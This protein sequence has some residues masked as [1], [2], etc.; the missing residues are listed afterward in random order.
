MI[1]ANNEVAV[2]GTPAALVD[3]YNKLLNRV[4]HD[5]P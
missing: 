3:A 5:A 1:A 2:I 4:P